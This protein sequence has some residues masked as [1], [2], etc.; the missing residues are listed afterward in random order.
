MHQ[1]PAADVGRQLI[2]ASRQMARKG[3]FFRG[4]HANLSARS[5]DRIWLTRGGQVSRIG[6]DSFVIL[7]L[8]GNIQSGS[9]EATNA[10][11]VKMHTRVYQARGDVGSIIHCHAP[12]VTACAVAGQPMPLAYEPLLRF[13]HAE[14]TPVV[15]WAPRGSS[16]SVQGI[17]DAVKD[18]PA[19]QA[20]ML[21]NHGVLAFG[22]D[23]EQA[24][25]SWPRW[26]RRPS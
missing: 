11:I 2:A 12:N 23:P 6:P 21:A 1:T 5:G 8:Q 26:T 10:E 15:P 25:Q 13:G 20:V 19:L 24:V 17:V 7:D 4:E 14:A 3:L 22:E 9:L 18:R 16:A